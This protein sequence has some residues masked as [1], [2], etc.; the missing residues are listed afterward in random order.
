MLT[1][2]DCCPIIDNFK[3]ITATQKTALVSRRHHDNSR[4]SGH[5]LFSE[6][7]EQFKE[8]CA[9]FRTGLSLNVG[10]PFEPMP[11]C[12]AQSTELN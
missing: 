6:G 4:L 3:K 5:L 11:S 2:K 12:M 10:Q 8:H 9:N 7:S 1:D